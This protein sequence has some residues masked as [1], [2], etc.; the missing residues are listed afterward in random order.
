MKAKYLEYK[1][2]LQ[3]VREQQG[4]AVRDMAQGVIN[5]HNNRSNSLNIVDLGR[6]ERVI[7]HIESRGKIPCPR[8]R[9][10]Y[11]LKLIAKWM[12][13]VTGIKYLPEYIMENL[14]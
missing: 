4:I 10:T 9:K 3:I 8:P 12:T 13:E 6:I 7:Q 14:K 11:E 5:L 2:Q 1:T